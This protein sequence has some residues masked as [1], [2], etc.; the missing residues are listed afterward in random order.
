MVPATASVTAVGVISPAAALAVA[1]GVIVSTQVA[2]GAR[3]PQFAG[4]MVAPAGNAGDAAY[5]T[6]VAVVLPVLVRVNV[7]GFPVK[8][9]DSA[10]SLTAS[11][12]D[13][14]LALSVVVV[15]PGSS[16]PLEPLLPRQP[17]PTMPGTMRSSEYSG[18]FFK[19]SLDSVSGSTGALRSGN[20]R[21]HG[22]N[23]GPG[24]NWSSNKRFRV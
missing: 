10:V 5:P 12:S 3:S 18:I 17:D 2:A 13:G 6:D 21:L 19:A 16:V 20:R 14:A 24:P 4:E 22:R 1:P 15:G 23:W 9:A 7:R 8:L 11:A